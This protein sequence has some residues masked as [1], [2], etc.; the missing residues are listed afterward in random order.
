[1]S[2][3]AQC[4]CF[5]SVTP[6]VSGRGLALLVCL[7]LGGQSL[8]LAL[9]PLVTATVVQWGQPPVRL[10]SCAPAP[11]PARWLWA[12]CSPSGTR[13]FLICKVGALPWLTLRMAGSFHKTNPVSAQRVPAP[14]R[15]LRVTVSPASWELLEAQE[16]LTCWASL[17]L[18]SAASSSGWAPGG[19]HPPLHREA[20]GA[21]S[22][23][24]KQNLDGHLLSWEEETTEPLASSRSESLSAGAESPREEVIGRLGLWDSKL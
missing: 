17:L 14:Q 10:G 2:P 16:A 15:L 23:P 13:R 7:R 11:V 1:M 19:R 5:L 18:C 24:Q 8:S 22:L 20:K 9:S 21:F 12:S 4:C 6:E 3:R